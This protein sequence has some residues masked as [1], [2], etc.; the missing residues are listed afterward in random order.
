MRRLLWEVELRKTY[1]T[2]AVLAG[3]LLSQHAT[4]C[5]VERSWSQVRQVKV[6]SRVASLFYFWHAEPTLGRVPCQL[7]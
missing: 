1:P 2:L 3:R 6:E 5:F 4:V 7:V